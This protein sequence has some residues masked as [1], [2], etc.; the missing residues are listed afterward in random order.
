MSLIQHI[1]IPNELW[2]G[3]YQTGSS[4]ICSPPVT[5]TDIDFIIYTN[6]MNKLLTFLEDSDFIFSVDEDNY[7]LEEE[8]FRC[9]RRGYLNLILT[10]D[11]IFYH[12]WV[13]ATKLAKKL[14]LLKKEDR[15]ALF[16]EILYPYV[17]EITF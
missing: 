17:P 15:I 11:A 14:N 16:T 8:G 7:P 6:E 3:I 10:G 4:V 5:D 13:R 1:V 9:C 12:R 2:E